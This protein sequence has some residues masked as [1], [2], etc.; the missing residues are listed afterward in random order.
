ML[1][2]VG[3][4]RWTRGPT[5]CSQVSK[6]LDGVRRYIRTNEF[7][8]PSGENAL[9]FSSHLGTLAQKGNLLP[10][11]YLDWRHIPIK[12]KEIFGNLS[13]YND[14]FFIYN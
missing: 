6:R 11:C 7:G 12:K 8:Q 13:W 3:D 9:Q 10:I 14:F 2:Y 5:T 1:I 4:V